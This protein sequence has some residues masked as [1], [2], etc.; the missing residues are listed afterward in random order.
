LIV[1]GTITNDGANGTNGSDW[2]KGAGAGG[3]G[4]LIYIITR[5][6]D[7]TGSV[8]STGGTGGTGQGLSSWAGGNGGAGTVIIEQILANG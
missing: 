6:Y 4:G 2:D 3:G 1:S 8:A 7:N 5:S